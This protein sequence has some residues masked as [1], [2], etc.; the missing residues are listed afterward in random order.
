MHWLAGLTNKHFIAIAVLAMG[1]S[2]LAD[3]Q[4][5]RGATIY[6]EKCQMCHQAAGQGAPPVYPPLAKSDFMLADRVRAIR[7]VCEGL[8]GPIVVNGQSYTNAMPAQILD[9]GK[10]ADVLTYAFNSWENVGEPFT[11]EEVRKVRATTRFPTFDAL[12]QAASYRPLPRPPDG[13]TVREV[14]QLP[15]FCTRLASDGKGQRVYVLQQGG[16][17]YLLDLP[18]AGLAPLWKPE[19]YLDLS[20]GD[21]T[22]LGCTVDD[23]GRFWLV[24]NQKIHQEN[25]FPLNEVVIWRTDGAAEAE[26]AK[27]IPWFRTSYPHGIG[28]YNHGVSM[29]AIG[30]DG[31]LYVSSGSRTDGGEPG[32][33]ANSYPGGEVEN[34]ACIWRLDPKAQVPRIE[35]LASGLRNVY[36]FAWDGA[37]RLFTVSNGPNENSPEEMDFIQRGRHYGF[38]YQYSDWPVKPGSPYP[39]TPAPPDGVE[40]THPVANL[41]PAAGGKPGGLATFD[42]HSSPGGLV[43]CGAD[44][45]EPFR[46]KFLITRFGNLLGPPASPEDVGFDLISAR[47]DRTSTGAWEA[48]METILAPL[49]RPLDIHSIGGGR[50]LI[51][52]YTRP[53]NFKDQLGWLPG[54]I[55]ELAPK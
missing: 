48:R 15:D 12:V 24:T 9:D 37:R 51:L 8:S 13:W 23:E 10:M 45:P 7:V 46:E 50:L 25:S 31:M 29:I 36:G 47:L 1:V 49:G 30:P 19:D 44:F 39:H 22:A 16:G 33:D 14:A 26:G 20:R 52:E 27:P 41:G 40:F 55:I 18:T 5:K 43:W 2:A 35:V 4:M 21:V 34:T 38:P 17:V 11:A 53:T 42:A 6:T 54:R 3:E 32:P 28:G